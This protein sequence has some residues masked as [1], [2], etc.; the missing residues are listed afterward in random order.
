MCLA[1]P[2]SVRVCVCLCVCLC[3]CVCLCLCVYLCM[4]VLA[5]ACRQ[6]KVVLPV[7]TRLDHYQDLIGLT[8]S[9][10]SNKYVNMSY[11]QYR[12][13]QSHKSINWLEFS[14]KT[15]LCRL[16]RFVSVVTIAS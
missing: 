16:T 14:I 12:S 7:F 9:V 6:C 11:E 15:G 10:Y 3:V 5:S 4:C 1:L 8:Q 2:T 13:S